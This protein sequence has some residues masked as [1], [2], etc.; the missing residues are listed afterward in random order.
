LNGSIGLSDYLSKL[1]NLDG[2]VQ[3]TEI[4]NLDFIAHGQIPPN[5]SELLM[6]SRFD[7]LL[8]WGKENYDIVIID[9]PPVLAV[10]DASII[11]KYVG[12]TL[13]VGRFEV[14]T[15]KEIEVAIRRFEQNGIDVKGI[16]LNAMIK[17]ASN[18]YSYDG[19]SYEQYSYKK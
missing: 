12:T 4:E 8:A 13:L 15:V 16:I 14:N 11:G 19:Y 2:V 9:T 17:K 1:I 10:T 7:D 3:K 18:Y 6:L 5:P